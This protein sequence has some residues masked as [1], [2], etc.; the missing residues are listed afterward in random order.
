[1]RF[2]RWLARR[3]PAWPAFRELVE[4]AATDGLIAAALDFD[5]ARVPKFKDYA[6]RKIKWAILDAVK[7]GV[8]RDGIFREKVR[9]RRAVS[10][11]SD[12]PRFDEIDS[13]SEVDLILRY[14]P[15][16]HQR[17]MRLR[18]EGLNQVEIAK[19]MGVSRSRISALIRESAG[20]ISPVIKM[21]RRAC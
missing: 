7:N 19:Q 4:D 5:P 11:T 3:P 20:F 10:P 21:R 17:C 12:D 13:A 2:A 18:L 1:M 8:R 15:R 9:S 14:L 16:Q 6:G